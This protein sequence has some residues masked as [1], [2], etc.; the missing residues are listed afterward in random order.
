LDSKLPAYG[1]EVVPL[2]AR[3]VAFRAAPSRQ[4]RAPSRVATEADRARY[5]A[6]MS[7]DR[8]W[9]LLDAA[10]RRG[11]HDCE[12]VARALQGALSRL[13]ADEILGFALRHEEFMV[14]SYR[15]DLWAVAY[16]VN[17]GASDDGFTYFRA[18]LI[19]QGRERFEAALKHPPD[20]VRGLITGAAGTGRFE[21]E[22]LLYP[23]YEAYQAKTGQL[24]PA[25]GLPFPGVPAGAPWREED[26]PGLYPELSDQMR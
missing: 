18:W 16:I 17:G 9:T 13:D 12:R 4:D 11:G 3:V 19:G 15:F 14:R 8:F 5:A 2:S 1:I 24:L 10:A 7:E 20:A 6:R 25:M 26:L 21:C 22:A 23:A